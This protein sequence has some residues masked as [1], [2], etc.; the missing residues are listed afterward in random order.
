MH[1]ANNDSAF[2]YSDE[3]FS[4]A[5]LSFR[6]RIEISDRSQ[7]S[8]LAVGVVPGAFPIAN[9]VLSS[10]P[11]V[12]AAGHGVELINGVVLVDGVAAGPMRD[13]ICA[14]RDEYVFTLD[15]REGALRA[16]RGARDVTKLCDLR[17]GAVR[18]VIVMAGGVT[19]HLSFDCE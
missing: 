2:V 12:L 4:Q 18:P 8:Y 3:V 10:N 9:Q 5:V 1:K 14:D 11:L 6:L 16:Q 17:S 15:L 13:L 7:Q 19:L